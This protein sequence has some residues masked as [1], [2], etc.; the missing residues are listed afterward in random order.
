[1]VSFNPDSDIPDLSGKVVL[2]TG[3]NIGLGK[4]TVLQLSKHNPAHIFLAARTESKATEAIKEIQAAVPNAAKITFLQLD[5][6][7]F[8]SIKKAAASFLSQSS[9]LHLLI[10]NA[11][12]MATPPGTTKEGYEE[13]FGTNHM[14]HALLTKL[15]L[16]TL[17]ATA[18]NAPPQSVRVVVLSSLVEKYATPAATYDFAKLKTNWA[19][20]STSTRYAVSKIAN[21]HYASELARRNPEL[22]V[23]SVHPGVVNTNLMSGPAK[24]YPWMRPLRPIIGFFL[25]S[26]PEGTKNQLWAAVSP[27]AKSGEFYYPVGLANKGS[28][29][30]K[31]S[32]LALELWDWTEKEL[33]AHL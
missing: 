15:L 33:A 7:S 5:L 17:K 13:Q 14:G 31:N 16:P 28:D 3:G 11:G 10:N 32:K 24:T 6:M 4:E 1:M 23:V 26:V 21:I 12:I 19:D 8:D 29:L 30:S 25:T 9:Q 18:A 22:R 20:L 2:V 27:D